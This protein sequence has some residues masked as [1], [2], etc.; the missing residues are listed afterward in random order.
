MRWNMGTAD[1]WTINRTCGNPS[2]VRPDHL[3]SGSLVRDDGKKGK[4]RKPRPDW[5]LYPHRSGQWAK[6]IRGKTHY[7]GPW[8]AP[9]AALQKYLDERDD[10]HAGR[11]PHSKRGGLTMRELCN[12]FLSA[13]Q[14]HATLAR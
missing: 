6:K 14:Q 13:K 12:R 3:Q 11:T 2:C 5:P 10:L 1:G 4:P 7:F 9:E 8:P